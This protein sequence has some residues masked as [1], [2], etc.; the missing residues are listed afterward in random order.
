MDN[1]IKK[2]MCISLY[3]LLVPLQS[4]SR[5]GYDKYP[6]NTRPTL[7]SFPSQQVIG[8]RDAQYRTSTVTPTRREHQLRSENRLSTPVKN[9]LKITS[10]HDDAITMARIRSQNKEL[11]TSIT[12]LKNTID[13]FNRSDTSNYTPILQSSLKSAE[14]LQAQL[15]TLKPIL[16]MHPENKRVL[17]EHIDTLH[18]LFFPNGHP[19]DL[20]EQKM[21]QVKGVAPTTR[22]VSQ[23][24]N[25]IDAL[26]NQQY[27][28]CL[29]K[30]VNVMHNNDATINNRLNLKI[31]GI[32]SKIETINDMEGFHY[33]N[34]QKAS[35]MSQSMSKIKRL[36]SKINPADVLA[37]GSISILVVILA[38]I[39]DGLVEEIY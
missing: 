12:M 28:L 20:P 7:R 23:L 26:S 25:Y 21:P 2:L 38:V 4:S 19:L 11:E 3:L 34:P 32:K 24:S 22:E 1:L 14:I 36:F 9:T 5:A 31:D 27:F 17:S 30:I 33:N 15:K 29:M 18:S 10:I 16:A 35:L 8:T 37:V 13:T 6:Q 39:I